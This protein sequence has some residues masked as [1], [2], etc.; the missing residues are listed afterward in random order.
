MLA[1]IFRPSRSAMTSGQARTQGWVLEFAPTQ[2]KAIDPLMGWTGS[3]DMLGQVRL[4]FDTR[5]AAEDYARRNGVD[6]QVLE[7]K[8][9]KANLRPKGYGSNFSHDRRTPWTH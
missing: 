7:P 9:R 6:H 1:K 5:E 8:P 4:T 3:G 2:R